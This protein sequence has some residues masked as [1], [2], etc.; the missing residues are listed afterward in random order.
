MPAHDK[1]FKT[2]ASDLALEVKLLECLD[3]PN[4]IQLHGVKSGDLE[5]S[6]NHRDYFLVIDYLVATLD[7]RLRRWRK[8][9]G[10]IV[11][12]INRRIGKKRLIERIESTALGVAKGME[13]LHSKN[14]VFRDLKPDNVGFDVYKNIKIFDFGLARDL[15]CVSRSGEVLGFTGTPRYMANEIGEGTRYGL[16]VD[17]YSFGVLLW[18]ICT[19]KDP[20]EDMFH[21][22]QYHQWIVEEGR[23]PDLRLVKKDILRDLISQCWDPTPEVRPS[24][25]EIRLRLEDFLGEHASNSSS[26]SS[27]PSL[28]NSSH[29]KSSVGDKNAGND[30][31]SMPFPF[32]GSSTQLT[33]A[34][35]SRG[36]S[37]F[38]IS[39]G[40]T[41]SSSI[42]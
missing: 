40:T 19:L 20:Y 9:A 30:E 33:D 29:T 32:W 31:Q 2:G 3:H 35:S 42:R 37:L 8:E 25:A 10:G 15:G 18:Q 16:K 26:S 38:D 4:I 11:S 36:S 17:V 14:I 41:R 22:K 6:I 23:R 39:R 34:A 28:R 24:F 13:Y 27:R 7:D 5:D 12:R 1:K 21:I